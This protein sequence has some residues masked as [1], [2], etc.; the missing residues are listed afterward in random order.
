MA[1]HSGALALRIVAV[2][3]ALLFCAVSA[4][5]QDMW[6]MP[7]AGGVAIP[8][9]WQPGGGLGITPPPR[10]APVDPNAQR[11]FHDYCVALIEAG[12]DPQA[13]A[14]AG[15][16][17]GDDSH[18]D[19]LAIARGCR[20]KFADLTNIATPM[21]A[22]RTVDFE[23]ALTACA[24]LK[25]ST[26]ASPPPSAVIAALLIDCRDLKNPNVFSKQLNQYGLQ[27]AILRIYNHMK[28]L[29]RD[30]AMVWD[31]KGAP[32]V[33]VW[34]DQAD[35]ATLNCGKLFGEILFSNSPTV[36]IP[37]EQASRACDNLGR[38]LSG[39]FSRTAFEFA[40]I[41]A[42]SKIKALGL[43]EQ[44]WAASPPPWHSN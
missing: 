38:Q 6:V 43:L 21:S 30:V 39:D 9:Y 16:R 32:Y 13:L 27:L 44:A 33:D 8:L 23:N 11:K 4:F 31:Q 36:P 3:Y 35:Q 10:N 1:V 15:A 26:P 29:R 34:V 28:I 25:K 14:L 24:V 19:K 2:L 17:F 20:L 41:E 5:A 40:V 12:S 18:E 42:F 7:P 37:L 22:S